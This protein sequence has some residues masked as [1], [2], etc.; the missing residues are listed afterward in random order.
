MSRD[1]LFVARRTGKCNLHRRRLIG[2]AFGEINIGL[3]IDKVRFGRADGPR[4]YYGIDGNVKG[5]LIQLFV[6]CL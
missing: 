5:S 1:F 6:G 2:R 4:R 3:A